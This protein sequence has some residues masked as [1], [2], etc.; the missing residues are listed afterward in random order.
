MN[1]SCDCQDPPSSVTKKRIKTRT[2]YVEFT[3]EV[4]SEVSDVIDDPDFD[5]TQRVKKILDAADQERNI[6]TLANASFS[7]DAEHR[8]Y[9]NIVNISGF[10]HASDQIRDCTVESYIQDSHVLDQ[11]WKPVS[12]EPG[13]RCNWWEHET[14]RGLVSACASGHRVRVDCKW[15]GDTSAPINK[16]GR[17]KKSSNVE[18]TAAGADAAGARMEA[19]E[20]PRRR[21]GR[22]RNPS[23]ETVCETDTELQA[24]ARAI[25]RRLPMKTLRQVLADVGFEGVC[26]DKNECVDALLALPPTKLAGIMEGGT[27]DAGA[28]AA[29]AAGGAAVASGSSGVGSAR[30]G[31]GKT[32]S[33]IRAAGQT[34]KVPP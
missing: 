21:R 9:G 14:I 18:E 32:G 1:V 17:P 19:E 4:T 33:Y 31:S 24:A 26:V 25:F 6:R 3:L 12:V 5:I 23:N 11:H 28:A 22:P 10:I 20:V 8:W 13:K 2:W 27:A 30:S 34:R 15:T 16:G 29:A 7:Y